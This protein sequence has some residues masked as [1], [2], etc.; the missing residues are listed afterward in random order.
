[1]AVIIPGDSDTIGNDANMYI[2]IEGRYSK[3]KYTRIR[4]VV[5]SIHG[6]IKGPAGA[7]RCKHYNLYHSGCY[8]S[9]YVLLFLVGGKVTSIR[10][11]EPPAA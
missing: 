2:F 11:E 9:F 4:Q 6:C 7:S 1:M 10:D 3:I 5:I 8:I